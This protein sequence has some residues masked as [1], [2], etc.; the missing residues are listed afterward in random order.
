MYER[1]TKLLFV[2]GTGLWLSTA[3][4]TTGLETQEGWAHSIGGAECDR[5]MKVVS[6]PGGDVIVSGVFSNRIKIGST[7]LDPLPGGGDSLFVARLN[8]TTGEP[9]WKTA[10]L[11]VRPYPENPLFFTYLWHESMS[12][13]AEGNVLVTGVLRGDVSFEGSQQPPKDDGVHTSD[14]YVHAIFV[15]KL[16]ADG[17]PSWLSVPAIVSTK[18]HLP[19]RI[20]PQIAV[21]GGAD[22]YLATPLDELDEMSLMRLSAETGEEVS[23]IPLLGTNIPRLEATPDGHLLATY[24]TLVQKLDAATGTSSWNWPTSGSG[25][26]HHFAHSDSQGNVLVTSTSTTPAGNT[27]SVTKLDTAGVPLWSQST[28]GAASITPRGLA[29]NAAGTTVVAGHFSGTVDFGTGPLSAQGEQ[30]FAVMYDA[31][32]VPLWSKLLPGPGQGVYVTDSGLDDLGNLLLFGSF[33]Q[34][35][36]MGGPLP[37]PVGCNDNFALKRSPSQL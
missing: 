13:D 2:L 17:T 15:V 1:L 16:S 5:G 19:P 14:G 23:S 27:F 10:A 26:V 9:V 30:S 35:V 21:V 22:I 31:A 33:N 6:I 4:A 32:G 20:R 34:A 11:S 12:V 28:T 36:D 37:A 25:Q 29:V 7:L 8:A 24:G 3:E 18:S